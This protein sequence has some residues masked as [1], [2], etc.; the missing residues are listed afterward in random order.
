MADET[1][2][3]LLT[4]VIAT[5]NASE[6]LPATLASIETQPA[7][8]LDRCEVIVVDG[9]S[10]DTTVEVA[11]ASRVISRIVT[12]PDEGIYDAMNKGA[13]LA[14]G[15]WLHFLNAGD[16]FTKSTSL[17][18]TLAALDRADHAGN[19]W[20]VA[21]AQNMAGGQGPGRE[22]PNMPHLWWRHALGLQ[23]HCHQ[24]TWFK[25]DAFHAIGGYSLGFGLAGDFD[26]ILRIG[27]A[28]R[29]FEERSLLIGYLG[30]GVS[31]KHGHLV[32]ELLHRIRT[33]RLNLSG[34][35]QKLDRCLMVA[36]SVRNQAK[37]KL[38]ALRSDWSRSAPRKP[39]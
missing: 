34:F 16:V 25:N 6:F 36:V 28:S 22:I 20:M 23:S 9:Q 38:G 12:E 27:L 31:E 15:E 30:G 13:K 18:T 19:V 39:L 24:A 26:L 29:P 8:A 35:A 4:I 21:G 3:P 14:N 7:A 2:R 1:A 10:R 11:K 5:F 32:P 37:I 17:A 33:E